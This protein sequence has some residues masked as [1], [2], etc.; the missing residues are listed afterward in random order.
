MMRRI[1][2]Y[3]FATGMSLLATTALAEQ[4]L[5][6]AEIAPGVYLHRGVQEVPDAANGGRIANL[7]FIVGDQRVAVIDAGGSYAEGQ[8]VLQA[9]R[10]VTDLP[11]AWLILTHMHP[12]HSLGAGA[13]ADQGIE[14]IGH[15]N[16]ADA[17]NRR[18]DAY[19]NPVKA[20]L[21]EQA[22]GTRI[23][24][25]TSTVAISQSRDL[26]LG[27][28]IITLT[29]HPTAHT[30][31][32]LT[33]YDTRT[34]VLWLSD[35]LF[36][37]HLPVVDGSVLG[38]LHVMDELVQR[39]P[40]I[41]VPAMA[42]CNMPGC[43]RLPTSDAIYRRWSTVCAASSSAAAG[44]A[45]PSNPWRWTRNPAGCCSTNFTAAMSPRSSLSWSG[46]NTSAAVRPAVSWH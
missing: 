14:I 45:R 7:G 23:V 33:V 30:N 10:Q 37:D 36:V 31:N 8:A 32:D 26:D 9:I 28:R 4:A 19:L 42:Q 43:R 46:N 15:E 11:V 12:D 1:F 40:T 5:S 38:W 20:Y 22:Q 27:G 41:V 21:G 24:L 2:V 35:L 3:L 44:S 17:L 13:F 6:F 18:R 34:D 39:T 25:P 29:A 16:L